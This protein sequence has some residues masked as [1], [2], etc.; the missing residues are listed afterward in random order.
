MIVFIIYSNVSLLCSA[1][2]ACHVS[3][4]RVRVRVHVRF[5]TFRFVPFR[6]VP[7]HYSAF[8][9]IPTQIEIIIQVSYKTRKF[10]IGNKKYA[11]WKLVMRKLK[12]GNEK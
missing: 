6:F 11:N 1:N 4:V 12:I 5:V 10:E 8:Y 3:C 9:N 2:V 7:F